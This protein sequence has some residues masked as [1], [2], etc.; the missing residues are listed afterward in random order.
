MRGRGRGDPGG[1]CGTCGE[2]GAA[3]V[4]TLA[5][6]GV[7]LFVTSALGVIG[8]IVVTQ[9]R[10]Q[11]AADLAALAG[12]TALQEGAAA[13][14]AAA[15]VARANEARL[16]RCTVSGQEVRV[17]VESPGPRA[18]GRSFDLSAEARAGPAP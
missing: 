6:A 7:L 1:R 4:L 5:M 2:R 18:V 3:T 15:T 8:G 14:S 17:L 11:A 9:R 10:S 12:A 13:C 16:V